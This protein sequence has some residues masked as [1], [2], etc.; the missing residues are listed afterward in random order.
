MSSPKII[1]G[2]FEELVIL[3]I[4]RLDAYAYGVAIQELVEKAT[5]RTVNVRGLYTT[6]KRLEEKKLIRTVLDGAPTESRGGRP[7]RYYAVEALGK[8][9]L[10]HT[11]AQRETWK[12]HKEAIETT[13]APVPL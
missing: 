4:L 10:K 8:Q 11:A 13:P 9:A 5:R 12:K 3:A 2:D 6:L 7:R 1:L